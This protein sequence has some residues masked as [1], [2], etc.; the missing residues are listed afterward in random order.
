[1]RG[2]GSEPN[3]VSTLPGS[4]QYLWPAWTP[5]GDQILAERRRNFSH[6]ANVLVNAKTGAETPFAGKNGQ[7]CGWTR[8]GSRLLGQGTMYQYSFALYRADGTEPVNFPQP[9]TGYDCM[10]LSPGRALRRR[11]AGQ[12]RRRQPHQHRHLGPPGEDDAQPHEQPVRGL[13]RVPHVVADRRLDRLRLQ[14]RPRRLDRLRL[15]RPVEDPSRRHRRAEDHGRQARR[16]EL[17]AP[18]RAAAPRHRAGPGAD[19][20]GAAARWPR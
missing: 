2:D 11:R 3:R 12:Q 18:G 17:R 9:I 1:M 19:A 6:E 4:D 13:Q 15:D 10:S 8:D 5:D 7:M 14:P 16:P 20:R